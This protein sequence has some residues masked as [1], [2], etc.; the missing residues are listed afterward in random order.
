MPGCNSPLLDKTVDF[1]CSE[2][3]SFAI[4]LDF[5]VKQGNNVSSH[6]FPFIVTMTE[7]IYGHYLKDY[8]MRLK[9]TA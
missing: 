9:N 7:L 6:S 3:L 2:M 4:Y 1:C 5:V 8:C